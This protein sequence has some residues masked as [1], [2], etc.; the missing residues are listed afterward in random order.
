ME[1]EDYEE[2]VNCAGG[3]LQVSIVVITSGR[4]PLLIEIYYILK[5]HAAMK[6]LEEP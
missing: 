4:R 1:N 6:L 2:R 5:F 3:C